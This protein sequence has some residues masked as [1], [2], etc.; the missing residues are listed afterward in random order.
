MSDPKNGKT[1]EAELFSLFDIVLLERENGDKALFYNFGLQHDSSSVYYDL[2]RGNNNQYLLYLTRKPFLEIDLQSYLVQGDTLPG[3]RREIFAA[4][5]EQPWYDLYKQCV[6]FYLRGKGVANSEELPD[7]MELTYAEFIT[8]ASKFFY[9]TDYNEHSGLE[10]K[11]CGAI[12]PY[13]Q[14]GL[15]INPIVEAFAFQALVNI[16]SEDVSLLTTFFEERIPALNRE[17]KTRQLPRDQLIEYAREKIYHQFEND[18]GFK[19]DLLHQYGLYS[20]LLP[21]RLS[22]GMELRNSR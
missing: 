14:E 17:L 10:G 7:Q 5:M 18:A 1:L 22:D 15:I 6:L 21:F 4:A 3:T 11:A 9:I 2:V 8:I 19:A 13:Q 12:N 16:L 20:D